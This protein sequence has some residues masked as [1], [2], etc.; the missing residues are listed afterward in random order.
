MNIVLEFKTGY[1]SFIDFFYVYDDEVMHCMVK[2][3]HF[4]LGFIYFKIA[5]NS[6]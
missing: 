6:K 5:F 2:G 1:P 4:R 3:V